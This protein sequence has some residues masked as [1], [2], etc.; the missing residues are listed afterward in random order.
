MKVLLLGGSGLLGH[1][2]LKILCEQ[3]YEVVALVRRADAIAEPLKYLPM[4]C[5]VG[6]LL[7]KET[8][9][10]AALGCD[11]IINC[12]G[13]TDMS[14]LRYEDYLPVNRDLCALLMQTMEATGIRI[15]VHT[16]TANTIGYGSPSHQGAEADAMQGPFL[17][18]FYAKSKL[19]GERILSEAVAKHPEWHVVTV[20]P[21]FMVGAYDVKPSSGQLLLTGYKKHLMA[22]PM[23][24]KSFI[25]VRDAAVA[26][27]SALEKGRSGE[28]YLLTGE[29]MSLQ[30]FY[31]R[32]AQVCGYRQC[33][34]PLPN[35][36][37]RLLGRVGDLLRCCGIKMQLCTRNVRQLLVL[38]YYSNKKAT[39]ELQM[40]YTPVEQA[41]MDF[42]DDHKQYH[43]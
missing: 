13:T 28:R 3:G 11:A 42:F 19:E 1:N 32:Q 8:L 5:V 34:V 29:N 39:D 22:A 41:I 14:L 6:S 20:N 33:F 31:R 36:L 26:I 15:L 7:D 2:V 43:R 12:A 24:G 30:E 9:C 10:R 18:S 37:V 21:G 27:V 17:D 25:H 40:P 4:Q 16:S 23:G 38:E 35:V